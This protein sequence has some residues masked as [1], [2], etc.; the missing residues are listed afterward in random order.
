M[1]AARGA[2]TVGSEWAIEAHSE[3]E[4]ALDTEGGILLQ[5]EV[6]LKADDAL[7]A[8]HDALK[9]FAQKLL[10]FFFLSVRVVSVGQIP[11]LC[12]HF[13]FVSYG[14]D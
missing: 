7:S 2:D 10:L 5:W 1:G 6:C 8:V 12:Y 11:L 13:C 14:E 9:K 3:Y 4:D